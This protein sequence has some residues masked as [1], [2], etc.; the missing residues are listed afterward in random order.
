MRLRR[1][2]SALLALAA[3][4]LIALAPIQS[5]AAAVSGSAMKT[6]QVNGTV[7]AI[8]YAGSNVYVGGSFDSIL[9]PRGT[10]DMQS[11]S[12]AAAF[13]VAT[14]A[15][16]SWSLSAVGTVR[17]IAVSP[18]GSTVYLGGDFTITAADGTTHKYLA[19]V[20]AT[21]GDVLPWNPKL[22][23]GVR[24]IATD[25][26]RLY[27]GG[28][29]S[30][31]DG[32]QRLHLAAYDITTHQLDPLWHPD[33]YGSNTYNGGTLQSS[34]VNSLALSADGT[35]L[36][37]GGVFTSIGGANRNNGA[38]VSTSGAGV[39]T[40]FNPSPALQYVVLVTELSAD[41]NTA[42]FGGR[43]PGGFLGA[44]A[45][46]GGAQRWYHH[47][48]GDVQA[49]TV[50]GSVVYVGGHFQNVSDSG[51]LIPRGHLAA[52]AADTGALDET[53]TPHANSNLGIFAMDAEPG[54]L[55][56]GGM[57]TRVNSKVQQGFAEFA[58]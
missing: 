13:S 53:W 45:A 35:T 23:A 14:G 44:Y 26:S 34:R 47:V 2:H 1:V 27:V 31:A 49:A 52:F 54:Y 18:D 19:A 29:F 17:A 15:P 51:T 46:T 24:A 28:S 3:A 40:S 9:G 41:G 10:T 56:I 4:C 43:G 33:S 58:G 8:A 22:S 32:Q 16:L 39:A 36:Y 50:D 20:N 21:N 55:G 30:K 48:D 37:V 42:Y 6:W 12:N 11:R 7:Y 25:G 57:F 38:A 5:A